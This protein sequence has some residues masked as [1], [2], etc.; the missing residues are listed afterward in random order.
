M[1][2]RSGFEYEVG[3]PYLVRIDFDAASKAWRKNKIVIGKGIF[4]YI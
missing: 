4:Q 3:A 2:L 1:L